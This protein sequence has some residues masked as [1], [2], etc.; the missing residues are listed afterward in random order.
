M[1]KCPYCGSD[2]GYY[3]Y[4]RVHRSLFFDFYD[5]PIGASEDVADYSGT[6]KY[7][8]N[9]HKILPKKLFEQNQD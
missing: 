9:C 4:E 3:M 7:C 8:L 5:E 1:K 6:R 2:E